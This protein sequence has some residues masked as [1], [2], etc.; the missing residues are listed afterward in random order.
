[1]GPRSGHAKFEK[2]FEFE[3]ELILRKVEQGREPEGRE[4]KGVIKTDGAGQG[5][6]KRVPNHFF[7]GTEKVNFW[8][9]A[10]SRKA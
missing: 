1:M 2:E 3:I 5:A 8:P 4:L 9:I 10:K 6:G 7:K